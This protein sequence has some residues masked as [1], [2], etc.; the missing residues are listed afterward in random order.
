[1]W[2]T[3]SSQPHILNLAPEPFL[4]QALEPESHEFVELELEPEPFFVRSQNL[5]LLLKQIY[6]LDSRTK[7]FASGETG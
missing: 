5:H 3:F 7:V 1:M 2:N 4:N 6:V